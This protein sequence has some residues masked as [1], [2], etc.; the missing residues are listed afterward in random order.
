MTKLLVQGEVILAKDV[1]DVGD[2]IHSADAICPKHV[3]EGWQIVDAEVP[4][5][6]TPAEYTWD[7][8]SVVKKPTTPSEKTREQ[9]KEE[10]AAAVAAIKVTVNGKVFDGDETSQE[11]MQRALKVAEIT[12][13]NTTTWI[14]ADNT[15]SEV[16]IAEISEALA[17]AALAQ[18]ELWII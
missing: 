3:I 8:S 5:S 15:V 10:R 18:S 17:K 12:G 9:L 6:F 13:L 2:E 16:T 7:G 1:I 4:N 14:L 11:R